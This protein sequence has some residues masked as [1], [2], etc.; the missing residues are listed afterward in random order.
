MVLP[1]SF[2]QNFSLRE[3]TPVN[4]N[5]VASKHIQRKK[6]SL[7][8]DVCIPQKRSSLSN[9]QEKYPKTQGLLEEQTGLAI[10]PS[11]E[12]SVL[13]SFKHRTKVHSCNPTN[14]QFQHFVDLE[15]GT[16]NNY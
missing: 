7:S 5:L 15:V 10:F 9:F 4:T 6:V 8:V 3:E 2:G 16:E 14:S 13:L 11:F 12:V 1:K